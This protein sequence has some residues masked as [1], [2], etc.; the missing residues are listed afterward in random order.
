MI[1]KIITLTFTLLWIVTTCFVLYI[2]IKDKVKTKMGYTKEEDKKSM[3]R[4]YYDNLCL[5][6]IELNKFF[7][8]ETKVNLRHVNKRIKYIAKELL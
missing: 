2:L 4:A 1:F 3:D 8:K 6:K 7:L 5:L